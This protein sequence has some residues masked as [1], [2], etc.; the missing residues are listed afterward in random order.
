M[1]SIKELDNQYYPFNQSINKLALIER[2]IQILIFK[3][4]P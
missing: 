4:S 3:P 1:N 2:A